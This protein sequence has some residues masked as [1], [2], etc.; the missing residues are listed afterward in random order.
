VRLDVIGG[1]AEV[2]IAM[3]ENT[4]ELRLLDL[5][6]RQGFE[7]ANNYLHLF[8]LQFREDGSA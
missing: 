1:T 7:F 8:G 5:L 4:S 3:D 6:A 2:E